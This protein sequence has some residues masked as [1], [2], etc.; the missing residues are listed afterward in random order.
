MDPNH[1]PRTVRRRHR[2]LR[3]AL[4]P[5]AILVVHTG[6]EGPAPPD[7]AARPTA[8]S[9]SRPAEMDRPDLL[10]ITVD[11]LRWDHL[12]CY[13]Y[14]RA[15]SPHIDAL[16]RDGL[17][18]ENAYVQIPKTTPSIASLMTG[19]YPQSHKNLQ[20]RRQLPDV[21]DTLAERLLEAGYRTG[22]IVG[23]YNLHR[24]VGLAQGFETYSDQFPGQ[25]T[26]SH[27]GGTF[28]PLS[29]KR[30]GALVDEALAWLA[31][32]D[33]RPSFLWIHFMDP[34]AA[35]DP[36]PPYHEAF[37]GEAYL[38]RELAIEQIHRQAYQ[39]PHTRLAFYQQR[40]DGEIRYLDEQIGR[41]L[42]ALRETGRYDPTMIVFTTDHGEFMGDADGSG[43]PYFSHGATLSEAEIRAPLIWKLPVGWPDGRPPGREPGVVESVDVLP[44]LVEILELRSVDADGRSLEAALV[45]GDALASGAAYSYSYE[46]NS[47]SLRSGGWK[48]VYH[49]K[50]SLAEVFLGE[51]DLDDVIADGR[52]VLYRLETLETVDDLGTADRLRRAL[53]ERLETTCDRGRDGFPLNE[54][55]DD[56]EMLRR[57]KALG[58][59]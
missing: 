8:V 3:A 30:A 16:A 31:A 59:L 48:L 47:A 11:T 45:L 53:V 5:A 56:P 7:H 26:G 33:S 42:D 25:A 57:L 55:V 35:Y 24:S 37:A 22:G 38:Q 46:S 39:P 36:P 34:H 49:P 27:A 1:P 43:A 58:Y 2:H 50:E 12:G 6:C 51:I 40:Y 19:L 17:L 18:F 44:T 21:H 4:L 14:P 32:S 28:D 20:L 29:E 23:Q 52:S 13:G 41:L 54:A 10:L 15:T 9:R